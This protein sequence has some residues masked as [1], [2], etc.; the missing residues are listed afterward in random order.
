MPCLLGLFQFI[1]LLGT[2]KASCDDANDG[3][4]HFSLLGYKL[5]FLVLVICTVHH[6]LRLRWLGSQSPI[7]LQVGSLQPAR[8]QVLF[9]DLGWHHVLISSFINL[10]FLQHSLCFLL[11]VRQPDYRLCNSLGSYY[12]ILPNCSDLSYSVGNWHVCHRLHCVGQRQLLQHRH[13]S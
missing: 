9:S 12:S 5:H 6:Y 8:L 7:R 11:P 3:A 4:W 1:L 13:H 10:I 2:G